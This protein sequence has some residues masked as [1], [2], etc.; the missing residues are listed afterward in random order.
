MKAIVTILPVV[1]LA[2]VSGCSSQRHDEARI[3][4]R[5]KE[6]PYRHNED[7]ILRAVL[8][9]TPHGSKR[10]DVFAYA[11]RVGWQP[12]AEKPS[13]EEL[14]RG[15]HSRDWTPQ[16]WLDGVVLREAEA[17]KGRWL[18]VH[19][20]HYNLHGGRRGI[21]CRID[22]FVYWCFDESDRMSD[23]IVYKKLE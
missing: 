6:N 10:E 16:E 3:A 7:D 18:K 15:G 13:P 23:V 1:L 21:D 4:L 5:D 20:G 11:S 12:A 19:L 17:P 22:V 8:A 2:L 9:R 14:A